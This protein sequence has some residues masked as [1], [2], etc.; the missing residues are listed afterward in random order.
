MLVDLPLWAVR[1]VT[2]LSLAPSPGSSRTSAGSLQIIGCRIYLSPTFTVVSCS[3]YFSTPK[4]EAI[5]SSE[6]S[7]DFQR[8]TRRY[9][10]E[11]ST[12]Q[13]FYCLYKNIP[14]HLLNK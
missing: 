5:C 7:V 8:T 13:I 4:M 1:D 14:L 10:P 6:T 11:D 2:R 12:L 9:I 3:A